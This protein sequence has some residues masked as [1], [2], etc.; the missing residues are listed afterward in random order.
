MRHSGLVNR[1]PTAPLWIVAGAPGAGKST[2]T[3]A[4]LR[5]LRPVPAVLDK[6]ILFAGFVAE[7]QAAYRRPV[8]EREG[9]WYDRHVKVHE[10]GGMTAAAAQ[11]RATGCPV[12]LVGPFTGQIRDPASWA[13][14]VDELGGQPVRLMWVRSDRDTL[15][16][17]LRARDSDRDTAKLADFDAFVSRMRP[18]VPPPVPHIEVDNREGALP[19]D[20][21]LDRMSH[22]F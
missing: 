12:L 4:L 21:Q 10:Y 16:A 9:P 20:D 5:R 3:E 14:W 1:K 11:I 8:G 18:D 22:T 19:L 2:V 13:A 7:V 6:D 15:G 17:R